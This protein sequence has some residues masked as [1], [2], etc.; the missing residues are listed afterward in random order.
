[1]SR[2]IERN[3]LTW[4]VCALAPI[5]MVGYICHNQNNKVVSANEAVI[6]QHEVKEEMDAI[7]S[8]LNTAETS[9]RG[10]VITG[11]DDFLDPYL[12]A[13]PLIEEHIRRLGALI[14]KD[15]D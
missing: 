1:M 12:H 10:F 13:S 3:L 2:S 11:K 8:L 6:H 4:M 15:P 9:M 7:V 14:A 5:G